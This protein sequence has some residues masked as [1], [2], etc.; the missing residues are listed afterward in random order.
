MDWIDQYT[1]N[2][3]GHLKS[4]LFI[5]ARGLWILMMAF[6]MSLITCPPGDTMAQELDQLS[7][8]ISELIKAK[9]AHQL[10]FQTLQNHHIQINMLGE[11][12][13]NLKANQ[14]L[15]LIQ[16]ISLEKYM[17]Q[18]QRMSQK[19]NSQR[20]TLETMKADFLA[21]R[22]N[23]LTHVES[24]LASPSPKNKNDVQEWIKHHQHISSLMLSD[25]TQNEDPIPAI[26]NAAPGVQVYH[27]EQLMVLKDLAQYTSTLIEQAAS[28][29]AKIKQ[30]RL[31]QH[32]LS[33]LINE[34]VFFGEQGFIQ[35]NPRQNNPSKSAQDNED[36]TAST[37]T[38]DN[39]PSDTTNDPA[40]TTP[41]EVASTENPTPL[42]DTPLTDQPLT[43]P[44]PID[45]SMDTL[46]DPNLEAPALSDLETGSFDINTAE[47]QESYD[48]D[49][50]FQSFSIHQG[51]PIAQDQQIENSNPLNKTISAPQGSQDQ[52]FE[53]PQ[54]VTHAI[55]S[56]QQHQ[57]ESD[58]AFLKRKKKYLSSILVKL[59]A[60]IDR[61]THHQKD[62]K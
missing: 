43:D 3:Q 32:E 41:D 44:D 21:E 29:L 45:P 7:A 25:H 5:N 9:H 53:S 1:E 31:L 37:P 16:K 33:Q 51:D 26:G 24:Q 58:A 18:A 27:P 50:K 40:N 60:A 8:K 61:M 36:S 10:Q 17:Q 23:L 4:I 38:D 39:M 13:S 46:P 30:R 57:N 59:N 12:I 54:F 47:P 52:L 34:E 35:I 20:E 14:N 6:V 19:I 49:T 15:S 56:L 48:F 42:G 22:Q 28:S 62:P 11:N 2:R 55:S